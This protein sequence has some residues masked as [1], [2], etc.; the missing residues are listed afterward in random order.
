[1]KKT[2]ISICVVLLAL[3]CSKSP[4]QLAE[5]SITQYL[6]ENLRHP[7]DYKP[8]SFDTLKIVTDAD[9]LNQALTF[10]KW[11]IGYTDDSASVLATIALCE[12]RLAMPGV[13]SHLAYYEVG[14]KYQHIGIDNQPVELSVKFYTDSTF[15][16]VKTNLG[17]Q[18]QAFFDVLV[19]TMPWEYSKIEKYAIDGIE[20]PVGTVKHKVPYGDHTFTWWVANKLLTDDI[21]LPAIPYDQKFRLYEGK[22]DTV[23]GIAIFV[24]KDQFMHAYNSKEEFLQSG[25]VINEKIDLE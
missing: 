6:K 24:I 3:A 4:Q 5:K 2:L 18:G 8:I 21:Y 25:D 17:I 12:K 7:G 16:V 23:P 11:K 19:V 10:A 22:N 15:H 1:M 20:Y 9:T 14:H 13:E